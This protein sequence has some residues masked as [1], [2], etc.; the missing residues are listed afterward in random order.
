MKKL[1]FVFLLIAGG[2]TVSAQPS[3]KAPNYK[4]IRKN[5][6]NSS[7]DFY[8]PKLMERYQNGDSTLTRE[9]RRHLYFGY[10]FHPNYVP[11]DTSSYNESLMETLSKKESFTTVDYNRLIDD[12]DALLREDPFNLR[13]L[14]TK[15]IVYAQQDNVPEYKKAIQQRKVVLDA[16][17]SS[18]DGLTKKTAYHVIKVTHEY[19][20]L[21]CIGYEN[22]GGSKITGH[23]HYV[24]LGENKYGIEG[25]YFDITPVLKYMSKHNR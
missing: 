8:Y 15:L 22:I 10:V 24:R 6:E 16:I 1:V 13:A 12:A 17:V 19:D 2:L 3:F 25:L 18:G 14:N 21:S 5:I 23:Y 11:L 9:E 4:S 20:F 7:S